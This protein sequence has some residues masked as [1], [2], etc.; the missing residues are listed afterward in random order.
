MFMSGEGV[1]VTV[2][3]QVCIEYTSQGSAAEF[4]DVRHPAHRIALA[5]K[6]RVRRRF[7]DLATQARLRHPD[8]LA[9]Q[10]LLLMDGAWV[11]A[12]MF[13]PDNP[14]VHVADAAEALIAA[15]ATDARD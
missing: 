5:H 11:A 4:P 3:I 13:G 15:H 7:S 9:G 6:L 14:A 10:L 8:V 1:K 2:A 12:R